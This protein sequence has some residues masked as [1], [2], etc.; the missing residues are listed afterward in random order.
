[1]SQPENH[2]DM[3]KEARAFEQ[4]LPP[5]Q[6]KR[7]GQF[8]TGLPLAKLLAHLALSADTRTALDPMAGHG[9]LLDALWLAATER[10]LPLAA[11]DG[12][13]IEPD[14]ARL[15]RKRLDAIV[16]DPPPARVVVT[17]NAFDQAQLRKLPKASYDLV[18]TNPP[19]V[20][21][22]RRTGPG[23]GTNAVRSDLQ[24]AVG[25]RASPQ[26]APV[27]NTLAQ[28]Y[29]GFADLSV[30]S[31]LLAAL[32]VR[33]GGK[34]ALVVPA[35]WRSRDYAGV[36]RYLLLR[37]FALETIVEDTRPGWFSDALIRTHLIVARR[38]H[39]DAATPL[40]ARAHWPT[41][42]WLRVAPH[43]ADERSLVGSALA[44]DHPEQRLASRMRTG[45]QRPIDGIQFTELDLAD[46]RAALHSRVSRLRWYRT[47]ESRCDDLP[48]FTHAPV[49]RFLPQPL[50]KLLP[51]RL[52]TGKLQ[53]LSEAG[54]QVGQGL[55]TGCN[56]FF[57][58]DA[59]APEVAGNV[60]VRAAQSLGAHEFNAPADALRPVVRRQSDVNTLDNQE[61]PRGR[62]LDLRSWVLPEDAV[63]VRALRDNYDHSAQPI[64]RTMPDDLAAFVR[65]AA[66]HTIP[67]STKPIPELSAVRTNARSGRRQGKPPRFWYMLPDFTP[68][69]LPA[70]FVPRVIHNDPWAERNLDPPILIDA[71]FSTFWSAN[72]Q[73]SAL[74][75][76]AL[77]NSVWCRLLME[78]LGTHLG[79]GALKLEATH[80]RQMTVPRLDFAAKGAL[81]R[82]ASR[83]SRHSTD[84]Q[85]EIDEIVLRA[86]V[87]DPA[88]NGSTKDIAN[89]MAALAH[90]MRDTRRKTPS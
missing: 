15:C 40:Y 33:S 74:A 12:I 54:I 45:R 86:V 32:M 52:D 71:N 62:V 64:P 75:L 8:F 42:K 48:V 69:H 88:S 13:E 25:A 30:P 78:L 24:R 66:S 87:S 90:S 70:A 79:G 51:A 20:R 28:S 81:A 43:A 26:S 18:I 10:G 1:M 83:L 19:F 2:A 56:A 73:W 89:N 60:L 49:A 11:L 59:C 36:V 47:L 38:L 57:Y 35:T 67:R 22:Q 5:D 85:A 37:L 4:A 68:R 14:T 23:A 39:D 76:K 65:R 46:E 3:R 29:S 31:W 16:G 61:L 63:T 44:V 58:V 41:C 21:F 82:A 7:L 53:S 6:R 34:L 27:W 50:R 80:L 55:R 17:G 72:G 9:D 84:V 77:L